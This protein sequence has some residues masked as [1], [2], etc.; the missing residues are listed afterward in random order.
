[1]SAYL[2]LFYFDANIIVFFLQRCTPNH[3]YPSPVT[4]F[5]YVHP[6]YLLWLPK[7]IVIQLGGDVINMGKLDYMLYYTFAPE[8]DFNLNDIINK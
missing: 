6:I 5:L 2:V 7:C 8:N 1:M 4:L 3:F